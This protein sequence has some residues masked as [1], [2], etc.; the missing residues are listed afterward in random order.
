MKRILLPTD[1]SENSKN[2]IRYALELFKGVPCSFF[3]LNVQKPSEY[4]TED[5]LTE[6]T[7]GTIYNAIAMDN[8][9]QLEALVVELSETSASEPFSFEGL[10]DFDN[11]ADAMQQAINAKSIELVVMGTNGA[12]DAEEVIFGSNTLQVIRNVQCPILA[13][14]E[15]YHFE[16]LSKIL[17]TY[18]GEDHFHP[19]AFQPLHSIINGRKVS[20]EV[21]CV[22]HH[23]SLPGVDALE[24]FSEITYHYM[25]G[26]GTAEAVNAYEQLLPVQMH[27]VFMKPKSLFQRIFSGSELSKISY[28]SRIPL[29]V[30]K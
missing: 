10:F 18:K 21:L 25:E 27:V 1:F 14:P 28:Q 22:G 5:I 26:M 24:V 6:P 13:I 8:K 29:L 19:Q 17:F 20:L 3:V 11:L 4:L 15:G 30:L 12:T 23:E 16:S 9:K 2:A 7:S